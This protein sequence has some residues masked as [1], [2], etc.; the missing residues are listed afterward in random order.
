MVD[1]GIPSPAV[2]IVA[3]YTVQQA[4][5]VHAF[6]SRGR[7]HFADQEVGAW[8]VGI[9]DVQKGFKGG[10]DLERGYFVG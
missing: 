8:E 4:M 3:L 10:M 7:L 1:I 5:D 2:V 6:D 9:E